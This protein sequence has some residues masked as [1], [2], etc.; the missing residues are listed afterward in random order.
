MRAFSRAF[1]T[2]RQHEQDY[3]NELVSLQREIDFLQDFIDESPKYRSLEPV[4]DDLRER[5]TLI[6]AALQE[7]ELPPM[8][9][10]LCNPFTQP[11]TPDET[12]YIK[13]LIKKS[14]G[15]TS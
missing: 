4:I 11:R 8:S 9:D 14:G 5:Q 15:T 7:P 3:L 1:K 6:K 10:E 2:Y 12:A 13:E